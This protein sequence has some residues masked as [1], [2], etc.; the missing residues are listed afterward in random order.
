MSNLGYD[1]FL[2]PYKSI[3]NGMLKKKFALEQVRIAPF[4]KS[5]WNPKVQNPLIISAYKQP[6][7]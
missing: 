6:Q 5:F 2:S 3:Q 7:S 1:C 4:V